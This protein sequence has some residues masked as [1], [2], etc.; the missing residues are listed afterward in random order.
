M[1]TPT[2]YPP[3]TAADGL[4]P[5]LI[6]VHHI[7]AYHNICVYIYLYVDVSTHTCICLHHIHVSL[8]VHLI[9]MP[10]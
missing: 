3:H 1:L 4:T 10:V 6:Y 7:Y 8:Y 2:E 9:Y 5:V